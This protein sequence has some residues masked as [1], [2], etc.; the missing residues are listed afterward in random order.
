MTDRKLKTMAW[1]AT[2]KRVGN[3]GMVTLP[4][5]TV[6]KRVKITVEVLED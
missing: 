6:G 1:E 4:K 5:E 2:V 3:T